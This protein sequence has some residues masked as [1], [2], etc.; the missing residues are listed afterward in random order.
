M[1]R[2]E[3]LSSSLDMVR[4]RPL[5]GFGLG[6]W[7]T[8]YPAFAYYDDGSA[9]NQAHNDWAQWAAEGGLPLLA[10]MTALLLL[11]LPHAWRS[12]WGIG[13]VSVFLHAL[14]DY[15]MQQR[16]ALA[17]W[18]FLLLGAAVASRRQDA[19]AR[20]TQNAWSAELKSADLLTAPRGD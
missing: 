11:F 5:T 3:L 7:A 6:A 15:P 19:C 9:P 10:A 14:V 2:R 4:E 1:T 16:P 12:I 17:A 8:A 18:I 13:V 20:T